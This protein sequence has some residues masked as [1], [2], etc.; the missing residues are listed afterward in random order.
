MIKSVIVLISLV[1]LLEARENP[2]FPSK[3]SKNLIITTNQIQK[4]EPLKRA[5]ISLPSSA[6]IIREVS[7]EYVNLDGSV[8]RKAISLDNS[9]DWHL[10]LFVSQSFEEKK[11][12]ETVQVMPSADVEQVVTNTVAVAPKPVP[13]PVETLRKI[14]DLDFIKIS[15]LGKKMFLETKDETV[16]NFM[17][18]EPHRIVIDFLED[19]DFKSVEKSV[20]NSIFKKVRIGEHAGYYRVV[21]ELD[22]QYQY[23]FNKSKEG[24]ILDCY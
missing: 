22:G 19:C 10:P 11:M 6:R 23:N 4:H 20:E 2:F 1:L 17:L 5:S 9:I 13:K 8:E 24:Y 16:R 7:V 21:V 15:I 18:V 3:N 14:I 12:P